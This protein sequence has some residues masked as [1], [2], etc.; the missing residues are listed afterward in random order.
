MANNPGRFT[1]NNDAFGCEN[2]GR[3]VPPRATG[4]RNHCPYCLVSKHVDVNPGDRA[5]VC[6][7]L[8]DAVGYELDGKKGL[9]LTFRCRRCQA[10]L[11]NVSAREGE[12]V[13]D[14]Y[15]LILKIRTLPPR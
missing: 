10:E 2:C 11:R 15:D 4:C 13:P 5:N 14:D 8:M 9:V 6:G 12:T 3:P 1:H 7:G